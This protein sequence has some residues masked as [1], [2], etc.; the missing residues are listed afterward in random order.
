LAKVGISL[1][2]DLNHGKPKSGNG[3]YF[4]GEN[5]GQSIS[6]NLK[7]FTISQ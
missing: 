2:S 1:Q 5:D 3:I 4:R 7:N 6:E